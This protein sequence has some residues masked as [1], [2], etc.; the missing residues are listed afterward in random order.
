MA[1]KSSP[2]MSDTSPELLML[3]YLYIKDVG[4]LNEKV[5]I[6]DRFGLSDADIA[7][8]CNC[9]YQSVRNARQ[10]GFKKAKGS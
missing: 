5:N 9:A 8:I 2:L 3:G 7:I 10:Q 1:K 4:S 6:L